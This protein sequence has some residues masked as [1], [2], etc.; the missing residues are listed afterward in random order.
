MPRPKGSKNRKTLVK[1]GSI[2]EQIAQKTAERAA[3]EAEQTGVQAILAE[4]TAKLKAVRKSIKALDRQIAALHAKKSEIE[5]AAAVSARQQEI[6]DAIQA[7]VAEGKS[8]DD[9]LDMLR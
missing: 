2:E 5:A 1:N 7:L 9:I 3:L 8:L 6:Q 4:N